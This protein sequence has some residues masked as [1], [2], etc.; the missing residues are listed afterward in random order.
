MDIPYALPPPASVPG[1]AQAGQGCSDNSFNMSQT[2]H[3]GYGLSSSSPGSSCGDVQPNDNR[4]IDLKVL[5]SQN[6]RDNRLYTLRHLTRSV[7]SPAKLK[8]EIYKQCGD[9]VPDQGHMEISYFNHTKK[10]WLNN[11]LDMNDM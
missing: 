10:L 4:N 7:D 8:D 9:A 6:K 1:A 5:N 11:R 3:T 2:S